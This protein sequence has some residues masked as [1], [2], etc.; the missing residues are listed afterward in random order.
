MCS[1]LFRAQ[2]QAVC[3]AP[4]PKHDDASDKHS[5]GPPKGYIDAIESRLH[6]LE[7]ILGTFISSNDPR[8]RSLIADIAQDPLASQVISRVDSSP[9][10]R[11]GRA[12]AAL[13]KE[14]GSH[15]DKTRGPGAKGNKRAGHVGQKIAVLPSSGQ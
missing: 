1:A 9:F 6:Q 13:A 12:E 8:A 15:S 14:Q 3:H 11:Q 4:S 7:A 10:G 5:S 2:P